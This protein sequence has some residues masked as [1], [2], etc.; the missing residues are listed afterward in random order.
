MPEK[1]KQL[2]EY[3]RQ[4]REGMT[5]AE[6]ALWRNLRRK[7]I[8]FR[9]RRQQPVGYYILD[10][11]CASARVAIELDGSGHSDLKEY[12]E[13]RTKYLEAE[14]IY[15][16]RFTNN[17]VLSDVESVVARILEICESRQGFR[18]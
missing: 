6:R 12:D 15:V 4:N 8:G 17:D 16:M 14:N 18:Y 7:E 1:S 5:D 10:F 11:Y 13:E 9:F 3:A 2:R